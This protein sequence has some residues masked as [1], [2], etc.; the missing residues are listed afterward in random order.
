MFLSLH[1]SPVFS[2]GVKL[3]VLR[4]CLPSSVSSHY[5]YKYM[6]YRNEMCDQLMDTRVKAKVK[7]SEKKSLYVMAGAETYYYYYY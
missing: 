3:D 4:A 2:Y 1:L 6:L 5:L 7:K